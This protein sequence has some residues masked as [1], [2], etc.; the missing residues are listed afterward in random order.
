MATDWSALKAKRATKPSHGAPS[1]ARPVPADSAEK[2]LDDG[3]DEQGLPADPPGETVPYAHPDLPPS[4]EVRLLPGR[5]RGV[6]AKQAFSPGT[7]LLTTS[8]LMSVLDNRNIYT[9]CSACFRSQEDMDQP[10]PLLQCSVCHLLR[11]CSAT[12]QNA[13]WK[14]HKLECIALRNASMS[15]RGE[16]R[17]V[18]GT[19]ERTLARLLWK[20]K[21]E[22]GKLLR[23]FESLQS[24]RDDLTQPE[25]ERF[26]MV[27]GRLVQYVNSQEL[28]ANAVGGTGKGMMDMCSRF[29]SNSFSLTSPSDV[30]NIGVSIS[31]LTAL[32]NHSCR[33]NAVVVF[34]SFPSPSQPKHMAVV[35]LREIKPGEEILTSYVDIALPRDERRKELRERYK[36]DCVCE[37][38][39]PAEEGKVDPREA[40][41]CAQKNCEG[42]MGLPPRPAS[43]ATR[44]VTCS[45]CGSTAPYKSVNPSI[46]AAKL[47][48]A[49]AEKAQYSD[50][51]LALRHLTHL[52]T[53]LTTALSPT[54]P[55]ASSSYPLLPALQLLLTLQLH[56]SLFPAA[57]ATAKQAWSGA[58]RIY[59]YGH[60][61]RAVLLS[62]LARLETVPPPPEAGPQAELAYWGDE[63]ARAKGILR[64]VEA[65]KEAEVAFGKEGTGGGEMGRKLR[66]LV[67]DQEEGVAMARRVRAAGRG[68]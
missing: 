1:S 40:L 48:L 63:G 51:P 68:E 26:Y 32:F 43:T 60:P 62:T 50:P 55:L 54:P 15:V 36:F 22:G 34:P 20:G 23:E 59:P 5:G 21:L 49:D 11:Y 18:P 67:K 57:L 41:E 29:T 44:S 14:L 19:P 61:V 33:P 65:I 53:A 28:V 16:D 10:K 12:C 27:S 35:A 13:D 47:A 64:I 6:V 2:A 56:A 8:P 30:T 31:P 42:L 46:D 3:A 37:E 17:P 58:Q 24:H 4:L 39:E 25:Q 52:I 38:C 45:V 66:E 7:T 9:R